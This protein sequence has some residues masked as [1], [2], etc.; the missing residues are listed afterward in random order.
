[1]VYGVSRN[2]IIT[3]KAGE[4]EDFTNG[5]QILFDPYPEN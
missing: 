4:R 3:G 2:Q 1:M 5:K